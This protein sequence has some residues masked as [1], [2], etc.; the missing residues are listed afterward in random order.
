MGILI[1][2]L[3]LRWEARKDRSYNVFDKAELSGGEKR[4]ARNW[5]F[6]IPAT[7]ADIVSQEYKDDGNDIETVIHFQH[8]DGSL[9]MVKSDE[10]MPVV[11]RFRYFEIE[12]LQNRDNSKVFFGLIEA[13]D[14]FIERP[15]SISD[16]KGLQT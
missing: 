14:E 7:I 15:G 16:L 1:K 10:K 5:D 6:A 4:S 8:N 2:K 9:V 13:K 3:Y 11:N 12:M